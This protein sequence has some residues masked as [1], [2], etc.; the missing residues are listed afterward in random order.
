MDKYAVVPEQDACPLCHGSGDAPEG[1][2]KCPGCGGTGRKT[3]RVDPE[4][5]AE[6]FEERFSNK[7]EKTERRNE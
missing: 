2:G 6:H 1:V 4:K 3:G 5:E 7:Q